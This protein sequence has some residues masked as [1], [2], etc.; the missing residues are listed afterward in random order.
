[1]EKCMIF[2]ALG[3]ML[4]ACHSKPKTTTTAQET[5]T[6]N[7]RVLP[8]PAEYDTVRIAAQ[9]DSLKQY[10]HHEWMQYGCYRVWQG[11]TYEY[12]II[13]AKGKLIVPLKYS[14]IDDFIDG[15]AVVSTGNSDMEFGFSDGRSGA[16]N[17]E[18][19]WIIP[20]QFDGLSGSAHRVLM[21]N[22]EEWTGLL[23]LEGKEVLP[24]E[25]ESLYSYNER[26][27]FL[28]N[29]F[30]KWGLVDST[31]WWHIPLEYTSLRPSAEWTDVDEKGWF[32]ACKL[33]KCGFIDSANQIKMPFEYEDITFGFS[34]RDWAIVK[35]KGKYGMI[36]RNAKPHIPFEY[37]NLK[38]F[39]EGYAA[40]K[41]NDKWGIIDKTNRQIVP[42]I[43]D[44]VGDYG[45]GLFAV[46][47]GGEENENSERGIDSPITVGGKWGYADL[48]GK[49][50]I[51]LQFDGA[52]PFN[53]GQASVSLKDNYQT[54]DK[55]GNCIKDCK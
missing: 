32:A 7:L 52:E 41:L 39:F 4:V 50:V 35:Q 19:K 47:Q 12:G 21:A 23:D 16:V 10:E 24:I 34:E 46:N 5:T 14:Y 11:D 13:N 29:K 38:P 3:A 8:L 2:I 20:M 26:G 43:Y 22:I 18:G 27:F 37:D 55:T 9:K 1:M 15:L 54:I 45:D 17:P 40:A 53:D 49:L 25:Y 51:P 30:D 31:G 44:L 48:T 28:A 42:F 6:P 33:G 36:D